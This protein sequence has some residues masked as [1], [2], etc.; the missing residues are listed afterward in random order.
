[1]LVTHTRSS[2]AA[3]PC[4][5]NEARLRKRIEIDRPRAVILG[6]FTYDGMIVD[7]GH[8]VTSR[9]ASRDAWEPALRAALAF[10]RERG[11][12]VGM[13]LDNPV[14]V[15]D[16]L[17]CLARQGRLAGCSVRRARVFGYLSPLRDLQLAA[18][19]RGELAAVY[20]PSEGLCDSVDCHSFA[21]GVV[22]YRNKGHLATGYVLTRV[23][24]L[25]IF[26]TDLLEGT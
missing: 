6:S 1:L 7:R 16:P 21:G 23:E 17:E 24:E 25:R 8:R 5:E 9:D 11:I 14:S 10:Y 3:Q 20:D 22:A 12:A 18:A 19:A 26:L 13:I 2:A 4:I 15:N